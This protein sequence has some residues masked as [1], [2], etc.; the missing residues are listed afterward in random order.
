MSQKLKKIETIEAPAAIG[1]YSQG[2]A[3]TSGRSMIFVSGQLPVDPK[4]GKIVEGGIGEMTKQI[5]CNLEAI[6]K[7]GGYSLKDIVRTDVFLKDIKKDFKSMNEE[8]AKYFG[9]EAPPAR[10]TVQVAELP[11]GAP[12][13]I[14]CIAVACDS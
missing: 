3:I 14:S 8:Y 2:I 5:I 7:A 12:I 6:L 10:Q 1:P 11:L 9:G 13:E 4:T